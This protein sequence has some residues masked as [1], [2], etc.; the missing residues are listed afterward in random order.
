MKITKKPE[1]IVKK[2]E[3]E[4]KKKETNTI[5]KSPIKHSEGWIP[6]NKRNNEDY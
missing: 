1:K 6:A 4:C 2:V 5:K 3:E